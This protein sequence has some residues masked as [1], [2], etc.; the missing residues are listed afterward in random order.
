M[1]CAHDQ[2]WQA[3]LRPGIQHSR[4]ALRLWFIVY[5]R[6]TMWTMQHR[7]NLMPPVGYYSLIVRQAM[8]VLLLGVIW[9]LKIILLTT[10]IPFYQLWNSPPIAK[11]KWIHSVSTLMEAFTWQQQPLAVLYLVTCNF[12]ITIISGTRT[13]PRAAWK[14]TFWII[15]LKIKWFS[16]QVP[17]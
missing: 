3:I 10:L 15:L 17:N 11:M 14:S 4:L 16:W 1:V 2:I 13:I 9:Q 5:L 12:L 7:S 8:L 6:H